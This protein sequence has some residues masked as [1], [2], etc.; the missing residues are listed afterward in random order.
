MYIVY[1]FDMTFHFA[2]YVIATAST[3][4][5][6]LAS[7]FAAQHAFCFLQLHQG[8]SK[9]MSSDINNNSSNNN[10]SGSG[11]SLKGILPGADD[12]LILTKDLVKSPLAGNFEVSSK[13]IKWWQ[14]SDT[15]I[16]CL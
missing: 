13:G 2:A 11:N 15:A 14:A 3:V 7:L 8:T 9:L 10:G 1:L 6:L 5:A 16:S 12:N 4:A